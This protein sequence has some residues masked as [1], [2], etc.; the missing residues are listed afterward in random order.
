MYAELGTGHNARLLIVAHYRDEDAFL[1]AMAAG[2]AADIALL[3]V[4]TNL[5]T[6]RSV[7]RRH[8]ALLQ[9][10]YRAYRRRREQDFVFFAE[11]FSGLYYAL[12]CRLFSWGGKLPRS[13]LIQ[14]IYNR[15]TGIAGRLY[16]AAYRWLLASPALDHAVCH[17][18]HEAA[19]YRAEFGEAVAAKIEYTPF[20]RYQAMPAPPDDVVPAGASLGAPV[21]FFAGGTSN[22]DY[23]TLIDAFRDL[24]ARLLIAC[25]PNDVR[26]LQW[27]PNV[28]VRHDLFGAAFQ[29][30]LEA[31]DAVILPIR[32][33]EVSSGQLV[34]LDAMRA[35]KASIVTAGSCMEDYVDASCAIGI[36]WRDSAALAAAVRSLAGD[37]KSRRQLG[38]AARSRYEREFTRRA[39]AERLCKIFLRP[40]L[41]AP[42]VETLK[43]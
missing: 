43:S 23:A 8:A 3:R 18:S 41:P 7:W 27:T 12:L 21:R 36:P 17:A 38:L 25:H 13:V 24:D 32:R 29:A 6:G 14:L 39:F 11:Q 15:K 30:E 40:P 5:T 10:A 34:L 2:L 37:A 22:R 31:A 19:Y 35:G 4:N 33:P 1:E 16:R 42:Q 28:S 9:A 26:G 20:G